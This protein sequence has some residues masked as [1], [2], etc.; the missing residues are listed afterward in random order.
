MQDIAGHLP[1]QCKDVYIYTYT[2]VYSALPFD[3]SRRVDELVGRR[4]LAWM[5]RVLHHITRVVGKE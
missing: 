1:E 3:P 5:V 4:S 2:I